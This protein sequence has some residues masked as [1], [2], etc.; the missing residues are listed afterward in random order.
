[1]KLFLFLILGIIFSVSASVFPAELVTE[2]SKADD[3]LKNIVYIPR[4]WLVIFYKSDVPE[5]SAFFPEFIKLAEHNEG[6]LHFG[7][8]DCNK[9]IANDLCTGFQLKEMPTILMFPSDLKNLSSEEAG[10]QTGMMGKPPYV[11]Q[12]PK[13]AAPLANW[14]LAALNN[15]VKFMSDSNSATL[16]SGNEPK[17][18]LFS[19]KTKVSDLFK[20]LAAEFS[21]AMLSRYTISVFQVLNKETALVKRF[22]I[23]EFPSLVVVKGDGSVVK[24]SDVF[25]WKPLRDFL[26]SHA[27]L[28]KPQETVKDAPSGTARPEPKAPVLYHVDDEASWNRACTR[29]GWCFISFLDPTD[30]SHERCNEGRWCRGG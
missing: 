9:E 13:K 8:V 15:R 19:T 26:E 1:M 14:A 2:L 21:S 18:L 28:Q 23:S 11:Y 10:G 17:A 25:K 4:T 27:Q 6:I 5:C 16:L 20:S 22:G 24:Y 29:A 30:E 7:A 12:G 3:F